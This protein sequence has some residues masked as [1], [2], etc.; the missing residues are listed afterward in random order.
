VD[1][2]T[3]RASRIV[4]STHSVSTRRDDRMYYIIDDGGMVWELYRTMTSPGDKPLR[5]TVNS[6]V[7]FAIEGDDAYLKDE[8]GKEYRLTVNKKTAKPPKQ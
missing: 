7:Q 6:P 4:G 8:D 5:V 3:D 2:Q 1:V